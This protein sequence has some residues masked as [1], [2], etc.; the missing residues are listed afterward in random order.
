MRLL[1]AIL[2]LS[3]W[4][5]PTPQT[6]CPYA[7]VAR[8]HDSSTLPDPLS[9]PKDAPN[10]TFGPELTFDRG[11]LSERDAFARLHAAFSAQAKALGFEVHKMG[12][13]KDSE[14][15]D[16]L[17]ANAFVVSFPGEKSYTPVRVVFKP[18]GKSK[19]VI[20]VAA[21][22]RTYRDYPLKAQE[23]IEYV[24]QE[25]QKLGHRP[26]ADEGGGGHVHM[27]IESAFQGDA[28]LFRNF[29][30]D[31]MWNQ[32]QLHSPFL[33][34]RKTSEAKTIH[35]M[36]EKYQTEFQ[37][38]IS[39][40]DSA[41]ARG[42]L[43]S[44]WGLRREIL[45]RIVAPAVKE[46]VLAKSN[47][48]AVNLSTELETVELRSVRPQESERELFLVYALLTHRLD[49]LKRQVDLIPLETSPQPPSPE[50]ARRKTEKF[51][52]E[53]GL[54]PALFRSFFEKGWAQAPS[55]A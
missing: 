5:A 39:E 37:K 50:E 36:G 7:Q 19:P 40:F 13:L 28:R 35:D 41:L 48:M 34:S 1:L 2:L 32:P 10:P 30:V 46:G 20:E 14:R 6:P 11:N 38:I 49:H 8:H 42:E 43:V 25:M 52:E 51:I 27:G 26:R 44:A 21:S 17:S 55:D 22:P 33:R 23:A 47:N 29:V 24:F 31:L 15:G 9:W 16:F 18:D 3:S 4:A 45:A 53:S 12:E 54:Q